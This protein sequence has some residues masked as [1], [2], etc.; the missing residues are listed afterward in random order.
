MEKREL[1]QIGEMAKMFHL[2]VG[3]LRYYEKIGLLMEREL[4]MKGIMDHP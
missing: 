1:F 2:S 4:W 3:S